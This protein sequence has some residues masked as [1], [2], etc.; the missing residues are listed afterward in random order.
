MQ[1]ASKTPL[2]I[3]VILTIMRRDAGET[4]SFSAGSQYN[5]APFAFPPL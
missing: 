1:S 3:E 5:V 4:G 2:A